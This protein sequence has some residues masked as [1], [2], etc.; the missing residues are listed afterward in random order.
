MKGPCARGRVIAWALVAGGVSGCAAGADPAEAARAATETWRQ[1]SGARA[2]EELEGAPGG[3][4]SFAPLEAASPVI[5]LEVPRHRTAVVSLPVGAR[6]PRPVVVA[7]HGAGDRPE[8]QCRF[9]RGIVGDRA[10]VLCPRGFATNPH[11]PPDQTGYFYTTHHMLGEEVT[12]ALRALGERFG[13]HVDLGSPVF[14]GFSQG[15]IMGAL[16]LPSHPARFGRAVLVEGGYGLFQEW[17]R[18]VARRLRERGGERVLIACGRAACAR[19]A[20]VSAG[21]MESEGLRVRV[22]HAPGGG[23]TYGGAVGAEVAAAFAWVVEG[24]PRFAGP[25]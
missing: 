16:V 4:A 1:T 15:A 8:E 3:A 10:F 19:E 11:A 20:E 12:A 13:G 2:R 21:Y 17:N 18:H 25:R 24:D 14:A 22:V 5:A 6:G 9:W 23:H 7:A